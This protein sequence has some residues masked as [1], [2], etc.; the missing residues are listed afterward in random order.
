MDIFSAKKTNIIA[1]NV[2]SI[3]SIKCH[4]KKSKILLYFA[5]TFISD[6]ITIDNYYNLLL[7][8]AKSI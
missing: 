1:A 5:Y 4:S 2:T 7:C 6:H 8:K 3:A